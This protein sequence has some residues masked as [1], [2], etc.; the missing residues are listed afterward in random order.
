MKNFNKKLSGVE[1]SIFS[2]ITRKANLLG[3]VNLAQGFPSYDGPDWVKEACINALKAGPNQYGPATGDPILVE[4]IQ[5]IYKKFY[6]LDYNKENEITVGV[7]ASEPLFNCITS[8][9]NPGDEVLLISPVYNL[10]PPVINLAGGIVKEYRLEAPGF[11]FNP[12]D[13]ESHIT[14]KTKLVILN[15][16]NNPTGK[17]FSKDELAEFSKICIKHD[18]FVISDEVYEFLTYDDSLPHIPISKI[19][20]M[21]ERSV[22]ISSFSKTLSFTGWRIGWSCAP[23]EITKE[24]RKIHQFNSFNASMPLQRGIGEALKQEQGRKFDQYIVQFKNEYKNRLKVLTSVLREI[25]LPFI[26]PKGSFFL[27][28]DFS[29]FKNLVSKTENELCLEVLEKAGLALIPMSSFYHNEEINQGYL[30]FCFAKNE[31]LL[32]KVKNLKNLK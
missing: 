6:D 11:L 5:N 31:E 20:G 26:T 7:G 29:E 27:L 18:L 30:R 24:I 8:M 22:I 14:K 10:Y 9:V 15:N 28:A 4:E 3:A 2:V 13:F 12:S 1:E 21:K 19:K 25:N 32:K 16:P 17:V 23:S